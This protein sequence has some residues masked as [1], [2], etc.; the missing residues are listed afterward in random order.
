MDGGGETLCEP[1]LQL[2]SHFECPVHKVF[3]EFEMDRF[4]DAVKQNVFCILHAVH[5]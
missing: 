5:V 2:D 1:P 4:K 3:L